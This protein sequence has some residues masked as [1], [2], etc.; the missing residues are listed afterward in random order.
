EHDLVDTAK[1]IASRV[2]IPLPVDVVV[3]SE[4]S[5]TAT[6]TV[7]NISDVTADDMILD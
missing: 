4:F 5:E 3:A 2:S 7:K 1:D 6:A